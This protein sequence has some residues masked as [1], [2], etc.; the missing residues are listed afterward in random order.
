M[1]DGRRRLGDP[2]GTV[3]RVLRQNGFGT[4]SW[5]SGCFSGHGG[6]LFNVLDQGAD[7]LAI[8]LGWKVLPA[9]EGRED[10][11]LLGCI[12]QAVE[13][14]SSAASGV[15]LRA[16]EPVSRQGLAVKESPHRMDA[17]PLIDPLDKALRL[18]VEKEYP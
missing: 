7:A 2:F 18:V 16:V 17:R 3:V 14:F 12:L 10:Q 11:G 5:N 6:F 8:L 13:G 9:G 1:D 4:E 15:F